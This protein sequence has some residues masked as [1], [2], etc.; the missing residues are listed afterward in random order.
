MIFLSIVF[1]FTK[2][3]LAAVLGGEDAAWRKLS[4]FPVAVGLVEQRNRVHDLHIQAGAPHTN[5]QLHLAGGAAGGHILGLG[6][7]EIIGLALQS[8]SE[9]S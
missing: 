5:V 1:P 3:T 8:L 4:I 9:V 2:N 6:G 7:G